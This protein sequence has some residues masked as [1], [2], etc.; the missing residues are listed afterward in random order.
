M[1]IPEGS[2]SK[3][4]SAHKDP[5]AS[6]ENVVAS[7]VHKHHLSMETLVGDPND[8][9]TEQTIAGNLSPKT[10]CDL[11]PVVDG[12]SLQIEALNLNSLIHDLSQKSKP[13]K[14]IRVKFPLD[15]SLRSRSKNA[16]ISF[17]ILSND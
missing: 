13:V 12:S 16:E 4:P 3:P 10:N 8:E 9:E 6:V 14:G 2:V 17:S 1:A 5:S 7:V 15:S 11:G